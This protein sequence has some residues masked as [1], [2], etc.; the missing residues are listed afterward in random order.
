MYCCKIDKLTTELL[1]S[2]H[3]EYPELGPKYKAQL[4]KVSFA[5]MLIETGL[6][7]EVLVLHG[8]VQGWWDSREMTARSIGSLTA[9]SAE[10]GV[11]TPRSGSF[12]C[13]QAASRA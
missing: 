7:C 3:P 12:L 6:N 10:V 8:A 1:P 2:R 9:C 13:C 11:G 5:R 4:R